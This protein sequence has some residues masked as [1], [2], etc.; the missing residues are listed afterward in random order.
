M[1]LLKIIIIIIII[2]FISIINIDKNIL[3]ILFK[4]FTTKN[5]YIFLKIGIEME[6][7]KDIKI[8]FIYFA[9]LL[10]LLYILFSFIFNFIY[11]LRY[12]Y[13]YNYSL[14][15]Q[16]FTLIRDPLL[17]PHFQCSWLSGIYLS[18][19]NIELFENLQNKNFWNNFFIKNNANTPLLV[20]YIKN[21]NII[22]REH[23]LNNNDKY[24]IKPIIGGLGKNIQIYDKYNIPV[25][26]NYIIQKKIVQSKFNSYFRI[27]T[28]FD[29]INNKYFISNVYLYI[30]YNQ[31]KLSFNTD[32]TAKIYELNLINNMLRY[33]KD[34]KETLLL[35]NYFSDKILYDAFEKALDLHNILPKYVISIGWDI[36]LTD[37]KYYFLEGNIPACTVETYDYYYYE[38]SIKIN[39][40]IYNSIFN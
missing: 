13:K 38:K 34:K 33:Y 37:D 31:N 29:K 26:D 18:L 6:F 21:G 16:Y 35:N 27:I 25:D 28:I 3:N 17:L 14:Y 24:I 5:G 15:N 11:I 22:I 8:I 9:I 7:N 23:L 2:I 12:G 10:I 39:N 20:G 4:L 40:L 32:K 1:K 36:M 30:Q 19:N